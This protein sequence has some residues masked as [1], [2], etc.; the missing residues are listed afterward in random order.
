VYEM[1]EL[2]K[3]EKN[4]A[5]PHAVIAIICGM[6]PFVLDVSGIN[7]AIE[8]VC[9]ITLAQMWNLLAGYAG[10]MSIGQQ[11]FVGVGGYTLFLTAITFQ[12]PIIA[13]IPLSGLVSAVVSIPAIW[14]CMRLQGPYF[15]I[16]TWV[17]AEAVMLLFSKLSFLGGASGLSLPISVVR[18][19][20]TDAEKRSII[21]WGLASSLMLICTFTTHLLLRTRYGLALTAIR[22]NQ[23][24]ARSVGVNDKQVRISI[25][26]LTALFTGLAGAIL[27]LQKLR[28]SPSA[29]FDLSDFT[30][31]V[32]F[33]VVIGGIGHLE[34]AFVGTLVYFAMRSYLSEL[35]PIYLMFLGTLAILMMLFAPAGIWG[36]LNKRFDISIF[37]TRRLYT[38]T[39]SH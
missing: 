14:L 5:I 25:F 12:F 31:T 38:N 21:F 20:S 6:L 11:L 29:A 16:A 39:E 19:L 18:D 30:A 3:L 23:E 2:L 10:L 13:T 32:I 4:W 34:S 7:L 26:V 28:I 36:A 22:D 1:M 24:G 8:I 35:G 15:A 33:I 27:F 9:F 17:I 37:S